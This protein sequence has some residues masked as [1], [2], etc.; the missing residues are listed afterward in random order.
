MGDDK[1]FNYS[2]K[3]NNC[4]DFIL[5][6]MNS[7]EF[8]SNEDKI[9]V[10]QDAKTLFGK[11]KILRKV[12]NSVTD[13]AGAVTDIVGNGTTG[14]RSN[15][16]IDHIKKFAKEN[17][18]SYGCAL[19]DQECKNSYKKM[20]EEKYA[21]LIS[22]QTRREARSLFYS[23]TEKTKQRDY[24]IVKN[25]LQELI[26]KTSND[27][28]L[29]VFKKYNYKER[30]PTNPILKA[31]KILQTYKTIPEMEGLIDAIKDEDVTDIFKVGLKKK[32]SGVLL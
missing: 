14:K 18:I 19:S 7:N 31:M 5:A 22:A 27:I 4:S 12:I 23:Q 8:G 29:K 32:K 28:L 20:K 10:K 24:E 13:I 17:N 16:W 1:Y 15:K 9:F 3:N 11:S 26:F 6:I 2:A 21:R 25:E 30:L